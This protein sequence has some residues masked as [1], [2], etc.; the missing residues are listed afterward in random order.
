MVNQAQVAQE[1]NEFIGDGGDSRDAVNIAV[2]KYKLTSKEVVEMFIKEF[3]VHPD[4]VSGN[5][6]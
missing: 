3:D 6:E 1:V 5:G 4:N 2:Q